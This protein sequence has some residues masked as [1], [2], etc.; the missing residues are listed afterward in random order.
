MT[1]PYIGWVL[2]PSFKPKKEFFV[3]PYFSYSGCTDWHLTD[4]GK[5]VS[6]KSIY[7]TFRDAINGG[8]E[9]LNQQQSV[10]DKQQENI[11]KR[12][13]ALEKASKQ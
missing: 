6:V 8:Y 11:N 4:K 5:A 2:T 3:K 13:A 9:R 12:R 7:T 10:L 1:F